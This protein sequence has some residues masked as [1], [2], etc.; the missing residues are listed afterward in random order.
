MLTKVTFILMAF[1]LTLASC[2]KENNTS[3]LSSKSCFVLPSHLLLLGYAVCDGEPGCFALSS[4]YIDITPDEAVG[5]QSKFTWIGLNTVNGNFSQSLLDYYPPLPPLTT[6]SNGLT[7]LNSNSFI[8]VS[9]YTLYDT[10]FN[11]TSHV[12]V[13]LTNKNLTPIKRFNLLDSTVSINNV[14]QMPDGRFV[15]SSH[16]GIT[17][18]ISCYNS[19]LQLDWTK[20][21]ES[22]SSSQDY[23]TA[24]LMATPNYIYVLQ[25]SKYITKNYRILQYDYD[26]RRTS[27]YDLN[28]TTNK[29][30][31][32]QL[33]ESANGFYI[34]GTR[35]LPEKSDYDINIST[36]SP[37]NKLVF[38]HGL[39]IV[40]YLPDWNTATRNVA[41]T[42]FSPS[43][44]HVIKTEN[45]Y[46]YVFSYPDRKGKSSL[47]LVMLNNEMKVESVKVIA[48]N[49][50]NGFNEFSFITEKLNLL[51]DD[52]HLYIMWRQ[53][54]NNYF[55]VLDMEGNLVE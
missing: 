20:I 29:Y 45:G 43:S 50:G 6:R 54:L 55:Y 31:A 8:L 15:V 13:Y 5:S 53:Y 27:I 44:S 22:G 9:N 14:I 24:E 16:K 52:N 33:I 30:G 1:I 18:S 36:M 21:A 32:K 26:G 25:N 19:N 37:S 49:V 48:K 39:N 3:K 34:I 17:K 35:Y 23:N 51:N 2:R 47:A 42:L 41:N 40:D 10:G 12:K 46:A 28:S 38:E 11:T 7:Q 4:E